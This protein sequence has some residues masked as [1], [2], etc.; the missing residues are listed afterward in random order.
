MKSFYLLGNELFELLCLLYRSLSWCSRTVR[1]IWKVSFLRSVLLDLLEILSQTPFLG[2]LELSF[3]RSC[4][5]AH[6]LTCILNIIFVWFNE[7][8]K[9]LKLIEI[10]WIQLICIACTFFT[11][12]SGRSTPINIQ[13]HVKRISVILT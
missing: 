12:Q 11:C 8:D 9:C 5:Y 3:R 1:S 6:R 13:L 2:H 10:G 7:T 4:L